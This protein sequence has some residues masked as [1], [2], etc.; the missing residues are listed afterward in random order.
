PAFPVVEC[1]SIEKEIPQETF[2]STP[3][4]SWFSQ[5][6][7]E[8]GVIHVIRLHDFQQATDQVSVLRP[9]FRETELALHQLS[10]VRYQR[11][12]VGGKG[13]LRL[14]FRHQRQ[15]RLRQSM[16]VPAPDVGLAMEGIASPAIR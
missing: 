9:P 6:P 10:I 4:R 8:V 5:S 1:R 7:K 2:P 15:Q 13:F 16:K 11:R 14:L 12:L 3:C